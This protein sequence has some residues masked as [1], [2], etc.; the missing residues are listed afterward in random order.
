MK[1]LKL[2]LVLLVFISGCSNTTETGITNDKLFNGYSYPVE[3]GIS[4]SYVKNGENVILFYNMRNDNLF[5]I[6]TGKVAK[7]TTAQ[8]DVKCDTGEKIVYY[9]IIEFFVE[10]NSEVVAGQNIARIRGASNTN[11]TRYKLNLIFYVDGNKTA[12]TNEEFMNY[13]HG[14]EE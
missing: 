10:K 2:C 14:E 6:C 9:D 5:S 13:L 4:S 3:G 11:S 7:V 8:I 1:A 12:F